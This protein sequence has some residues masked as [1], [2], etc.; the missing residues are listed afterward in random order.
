MGCVRW[1][2]E[3]PLEIG[4]LEW[5]YAGTTL[6]VIW[7]PMSEPNNKRFWLEVKDVS[8]KIMHPVK[9]VFDTDMSKADI[10]LDLDSILENRVVT[11]HHPKTICD[12]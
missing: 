8:L 5:L 11:L 10:A 2:L 9:Y 7:T 3:D 4:K 6:E 12:I 1:Y